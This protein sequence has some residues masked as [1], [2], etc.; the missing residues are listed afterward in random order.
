MTRLE[1]V[2]FILPKG[3][4]NFTLWEAHVVILAEP[5]AQ[6]GCRAAEDGW[7]KAESES[8]ESEESG[9][10]LKSEGE[11]DGG[12][13]S[14]NLGFKASTGIKGG[15]LLDWSGERSLLRGGD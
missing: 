4:K 10:D 1:E 14:S 13:C 5:T 3:K 9:V 8:G 6:S 12:S 2:F 7:K 15:H 11:A